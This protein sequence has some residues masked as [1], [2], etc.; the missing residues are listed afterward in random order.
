MKNLFILN[1]PALVLALLVVSLTPAAYAATWNT[2]SGNWN[3]AGNWSPADVPNAGVETAVINAA[4][5]YTV[6]LNGA[7]NPSIASLSLNSANATL[8]VDGS[9]LSTS[10]AFSIVSGSAIWRGAAG[11]ADISSG[12][13]S[14]SSLFQLG[15]TSGVQNDVTI[16]DAA[17]LVN[18]GTLEVIRTN[19]WGSRLR[20]A[21]AGSITNGV[22]ATLR[23][24]SI[25]HSG[26]LLLQSSIN[27]S[28]AVII[29]VNAPT[30]FSKASGSYTNAVGTASFSVSAAL[31]ITGA[32]ST[33]TQTAG[34]TTINVGGSLGGAGL[35]AF[36]L[37]GG[38]L[39][40][41]GPL[42]LADG[43]VFT[44][45]SGNIVGSSTISVGAG[46]AV[47][48]TG[49][50]MTGTPT[51]VLGSGSGAAT[52]MTIGGGYVYNASTTASGSTT[53]TGPFTVGVGRTFTITG[54]GAPP[55]PKTI[56]T[57][58]FTNF[59]TVNHGA[60][61]NGWHTELSI[62]T[63]TLTNAVGGIYNM[64]DGVGFGADVRLLAQLDNQG[65]FNINTATT[66]PVIGKA[67][68]AHTNSGTITVNDPAS[69]TGASFTQTGGQIVL[70]AP[71]TIAGVVS[72][73]GGAIKGGG[74]GNSLNSAVNATAVGSGL[75]ISP[76]NSTNIL[77]INGAVTLDS[78]DAIAI[79]LG[80]TTQGS[81]FSGYDHL[82]VSGAL[83]ITG[84]TLT[85]SLI[86]GFTPSQLNV[87]TII[88]ATSIVGQFGN[89]PGNKITV[90][91]YTFDVNYSSNQI[92]LS[93]AISSVPEPSTL[94]LLG[95]GAIG[96]SI[97]SRRRRQ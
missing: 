6:T 60:A 50:T 30:E 75:T 61:G 76:G 13:W 27:N 97:K 3:V 73:P 23:T 47:N 26:Q 58:A 22:G 68:A 40:N 48:L 28:G 66:T 64:I 91:T 12:G 34:S 85:L 63:G 43:G 42:S 92:T 62:A 38:T 25:I 83:N 78:D 89:T 90:D 81:P 67:G 55:Q 11:T 15:G 5:T 94:A 54:A 74:I 84:S 56:T 1:A 44:Q 7:F 8:S 39:T 18:N 80:G 51:I 46:G 72:F 16:T 10:G 95:L 69:I 2:G 77:P 9:S 29:D 17:A 32:N 35:T 70:N 21:G 45:T 88:T 65:T 71:L 87:F 86:N 93:N 53:I 19:G 57:P 33:F 96:L 36:N 37:N 4:G 41:N 82:S 14:N 49:G 59:G 20:V 79:E 31:D 24:S 52:S